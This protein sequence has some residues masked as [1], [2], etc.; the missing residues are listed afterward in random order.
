MLTATRLA[1]C[2]V[3][4]LCQF[5][6]GYYPFSY[7]VAAQCGPWPPHREGVWITH[8]NVPQSVGLLWPSDQLVAETTSQHTTLTTD[9]HPCPTVGFEPT[10]SVRKRPQTYTLDR[11]ATGTGRNSTYVFKLQLTY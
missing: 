1:A 3:N 9:R 2:T 11:A 8:N 5:S 4:V 10:I 7:G 6:V